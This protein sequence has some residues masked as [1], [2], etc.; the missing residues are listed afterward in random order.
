VLIALEREIRRH[1]GAESAEGV[2]EDV[3]EEVWEPTML[4]S[5]P[6]STEGAGVAYSMG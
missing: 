4:F 2:K 6:R 1:H 5:K 3:G